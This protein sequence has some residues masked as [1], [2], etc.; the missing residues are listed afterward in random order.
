MSYDVVQ[1][2]FYL[3]GTG[4]VLLA[5]PACSHCNSLIRYPVDSLFARIAGGTKN[6]LLG[7]DGFRRTEER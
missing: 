3:V 5:L 2:R 7:S 1:D 6:L 4:G